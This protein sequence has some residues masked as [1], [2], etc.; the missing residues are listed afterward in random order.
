MKYK[1]KLRES[2]GESVVDR[3]LAARKIGKDEQEAFFEPDWDRDVFDPFL[4]THMSAAVDRTLR[5]IEQEELI[6]IHGD[7]DADGICGATI[8]TEALTILA[9][10]IGKPLHLSVFLPH[11]EL[12]GYGVAGHTIERLTNEGTQ[13]LITVDCGIANVD[14]LESAKRN[15]MDVIICDHHQLAERVPQDALIIHPLAPGEQYPN[16]QLAG[17]GVA[18]KFACG[19]L[20]HARNRGYQIGSGQEKWMLDLVAIATVTDVVS[21]TGENRVLEKFGLIVLNKTRRPG[22]RYIIQNAGLEFGQMNTVDIGY[23]IGPRLNAAGRIRE[24]EIAFRTLNAHDD[25][26][27]RH[28]ALELEMINRERQRLSDAAYE[29]AR[30]QIDASKHVHVIWSQTW[31][32]GIVGLVAGKIAFETN[33]ST[34]ALTLSGNQYLGSGRSAR[35]LHLVEAMR[36]CGD[37]FVKAGGHPEACGLTLASVTDVR[38]FE[39]RVNAFAKERLSLADA[40]QELLID[41][42]VRFEEI[43][44]LLFEQVQAFAPFGK[45]NEEPIF[46]LRGANIVSV[47]VIGSTGKHLKLRIGS[48]LQSIDC[49]GFGFGYLGSSMKIGSKLDI[50]FKLGVNEWNGERTLQLT[51]DDVSLITQ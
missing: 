21:L 3:L 13:L 18:F 31:T 36:A 39:Q 49:I 7:Y 27:A 28:F 25:Q 14:E 32:P 48:E 6:V 16:K 47:K 38:M 17:S 5:A 8:I 50:V 26:E 12:D 46:L 35:G 37:I 20:T 33:T 10:A 15:G 19:L 30:G 9:D 34:F 23:R 11:R 41:A 45:D 4:F 44:W 42:E 22:L 24:A 40:Q 51:L 43:G 29:E 1:W 2:T